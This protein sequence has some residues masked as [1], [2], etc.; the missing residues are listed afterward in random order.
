MLPVLVSFGPIS[1]HSYGV[2]ALT[3]FVLAGFVFWKRAREEHYDEEEVLDVTLYSVFWAIVGAR[4]VYVLIN[5]GD[6]GLNILYWLSLWSKPGTVWIGFLGAG[7]LAFW[8]QC[9]NRKWNLYKSLDL[10]VIGVSLGQAL[11]SFGLFLEGGVGKVTSLPI[12]VRFEGL[13]ENRHPVGLY[14]FV[15]WLLAFVFLWWVEGKYR[16]FDWYQRYRGD[17]LPGFLFYSYLIFLGGSGFV[18]ELLSEPAYVIGG[19]NVEVALAA[20]F[21][22][23]GMLGIYLRSGLVTRL[24]FVEWIEEKLQSLSRRGG[25]R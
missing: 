20:F 6:F 12:G 1:I 23:I 21:V 9:K 5:F 24:A 4:L 19:V 22:V 18:L 14:G 10:A 17:A 13:Y 15:I 16:R 3:A 25:S 8:R 2:V 11:V 7:F